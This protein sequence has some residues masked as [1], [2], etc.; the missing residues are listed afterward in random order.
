MIQ[1]I[2]FAANAIE[3]RKYI[4]ELQEFEQQLSDLEK[5][6]VMLKAKLNELIKE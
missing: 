3:R 6:S 4:K 1:K 2:E 5:E